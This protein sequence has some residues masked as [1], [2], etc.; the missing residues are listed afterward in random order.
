[1]NNTLAFFQAMA[2]W[3]A[4][5]ALGFSNSVPAAKLKPEDIERIADVHSPEWNGNGKLPTDLD[6]TD[7]NGLAN[8]VLLQTIR[9]CL[10]WE[11]FP[12]IIQCR[13][14]GVKVRGFFFSA[15]T[16]FY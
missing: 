14:G 16:T 6:M 5:F 2:K 11:E 4:R 15:Y 10:E 13:L 3:S 8:C 9:K 7:G 12:S 1:M